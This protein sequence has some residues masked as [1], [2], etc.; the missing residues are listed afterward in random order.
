[1][2]NLQWEDLSNRSG[3]MSMGSH[4]MYHMMKASWWTYS[5]LN[6][7][8]VMWNHHTFQVIESSFW[9]YESHVCRACWVLCWSFETCFF[10]DSPLRLLYSYTTRD[11][12]KSKIT[13]TTSLPRFPWDYW[14]PLCQCLLQKRKC[15]HTWILTLR[16]SLFCLPTIGTQ[17]CDGLWKH[18]SVYKSRRRIK[19]CKL[20]SHHGT[21]QGTARNLR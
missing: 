21:V 7:W 3:G 18:N 20:Q 12:A 2:H 10:P 14:D 17:F 9:A 6:L 15:G 1:M 5:T 19:K 16:L 8:D 4:M 11:L 13:D